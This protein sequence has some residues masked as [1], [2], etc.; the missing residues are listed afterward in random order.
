MEMVCD[1]GDAEKTSSFFL[2]IP[3]NYSCFKKSD[4]GAKWQ[5][6]THSASTCWCLYTIMENTWPAKHSD[7]I[8]LIKH[9]RFFN[10]AL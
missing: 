7:H 5:L 10:I 4:S 2:S 3:G 6:Q 1:S 9:N 8:V